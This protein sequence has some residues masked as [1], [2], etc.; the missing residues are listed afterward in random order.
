MYSPIKC[1]HSGKKIIKTILFNAQNFVCQVSIISIHVLYTSGKLV[2][3]LITIWAL[4]YTTSTA[5][6]Q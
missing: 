3:A 4:S 2:N 5:A 6:D 1:V